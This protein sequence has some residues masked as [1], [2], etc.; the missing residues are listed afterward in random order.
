MEG[1]L[2]RREKI[3]VFVRSVL[4][5]LFCVVGEEREPSVMGS[6]PSLKKWEVS[7]PAILMA[8]YS[9]KWCNM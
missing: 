6:S 8:S 7:L 5:V 1:A 3:T 2:A 4:L 9:E